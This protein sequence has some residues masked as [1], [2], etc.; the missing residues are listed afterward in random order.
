M[1]G[2]N[3]SAASAMLDA[4]LTGS[5]QIRLFSV[6]PTATTTGTEI[7]GSSYAPQTITF[8]GASGGVKAQNADVSFPVCTGTTYTIVGW[9][10]T[11]TS[12]NQKIFRA[13]TGIP[14]AVG[15]VVK[16]LV[17]SN[18]VTVSLS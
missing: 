16:F 7:T 1:A 18:P 14:V 6:A 10:V 2:L 5:M 9:A 4:E 12:G 17:A 13:F 15:D 3:Q 8:A 11:D